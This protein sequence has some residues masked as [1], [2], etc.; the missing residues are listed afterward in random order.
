MV[1]TL[2]QVLTRV[3]LLVPPGPVEFPTRES[4]RTRAVGLA[5]TPRHVFPHHV[6]PPST[7]PPQRGKRAFSGPVLRRYVKFSVPVLRQCVKSSAPAPPQYVKSSGPAP[8][9]CEKRRSSDPVPR[10]CG[11]LSG[12]V[13]RQHVKFSGPTPRRCEKRRS[14]PP[15]LHARTRRFSRQTSVFRVPA[16]RFSVPTSK[17][18][19]KLP[20]RHELAAR[21]PGSA[22]RPSPL[23]WTVPLAVPMASTTTR[24]ENASSTSPRLEQNDRPENVRWPLNGAPAASSPA[25]GLPSAARIP[26]RIALLPAKLPPLANESTTKV[27]SV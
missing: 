14:G 13:L 15:R 24:V 5:A 20:R 11:K 3:A 17:W 2:E 25:I 19:V 8:P 10:L 7:D 16:V 6:F 12:P 1:P 27:A 21:Q 26:M 9:Q 22:R 23:V 18:S 4:A